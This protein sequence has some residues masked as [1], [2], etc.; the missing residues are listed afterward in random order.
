MGV[1]DDKQSVVTRETRTVNRAVLVGLAVL[2]ATVLISRWA[3]STTIALVTLGFGL[4]AF[5]SINLFAFI[6]ALRRDRLIREAR[7]AGQATALDSNGDNTIATHHKTN[8]SRVALSA[9]VLAI[10]LVI[11]IIHLRG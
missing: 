1:E 5:M 7:R 8:W 9:I 3:P 6:H 10:W 2:S 4:T 11:L